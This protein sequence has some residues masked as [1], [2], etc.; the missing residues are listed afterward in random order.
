MTIHKNL[1]MYHEDRR[2][3]DP[4]IIHS[5]LGMSE[6]CT[7]AIHDEP[8]PYIVPMNYGYEWDEDGKLIIWLHMAVRGH[9]ID[10]ISQDPHVAVN[11]NVFMDRVG[12]K[13]YRNESHDYRSVSVFGKAEIIM[14]DREEEDLHG[15]ECL[16]KNTG[17]Y[18][19]PLK[20]TD[21]WRN[22]LR[23]LKVT[24]DEVTAKAQYPISTEEEAAMPPLEQTRP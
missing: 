5:I 1:T 7:V 9:R 12:H 16:C 19:G 15:L 6:V 14:P 11:V 13:A 22:R 4:T 3:K 21:D 24:A 8:W 17:R 18:R 20:M 2:I 10:L 23:I